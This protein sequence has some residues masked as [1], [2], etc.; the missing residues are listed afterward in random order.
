VADEKGLRSLGF[1]LCAGTAAVWIV[2]VV[3]IRAHIDD[4]L[5]VEDAREQIVA[6]SAHTLTRQALSRK[7]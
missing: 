7:E 2:A 1:I 5:V 6:T 4:R 3:T